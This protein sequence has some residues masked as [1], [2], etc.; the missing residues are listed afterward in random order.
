[1][2]MLGHMNVHHPLFHVAVFHHRG[3]HKTRAEGEKS[4][5][6]EDEC[7]DGGALH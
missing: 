7:N 2:L 5:L 3:M 4:N 6:R 1:M